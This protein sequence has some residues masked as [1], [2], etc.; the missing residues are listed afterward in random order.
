MLLH[1]VIAAL[2]RSAIEGRRN[3]RG[4]IESVGDAE[5]SVTVD[6]DTFVIPFNIVDRARLVLA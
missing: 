6:N 5:V 1:L 3:F 2:I 4:V